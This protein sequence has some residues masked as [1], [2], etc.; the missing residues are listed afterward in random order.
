MQNTIEKEDWDIE[1]YPK[2]K[3]LDFNLKE[4]WR[5]RDLLTLFVRRDFVAVYK[6]TIFGPLWFFIQPILTTIMFM[7]VFGGIAKMS[8][9]G[10][11]QAVFY[12]SGIV[13][14]NYFAA[15]LSTTSNTFATNKG[16]FGKVYFPR[17]ISPVSV[18]ISKLLT[19]GVQFM[20]FI[21]VF[22]YFLIFTDAP[23][24]PN[25]LMLLTPLLI[26]MTA[27]IALGLGL[28]ITSLT[29]KYRD[30]TFLLGF[31]I[32]LGMYAT[33]VIYPASSIEGKMKLVIM[34]NPMSSIIETFRYAFLG[35]GNFSWI[36][37]AYSFIVMIIVLVL[38][39]ITFNKVEKSFMDTV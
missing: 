17:I 14:W 22:A 37:L 4:V 20:L 21:V 25:V 18:V 11:P 3:L 15:A 30:F 6:Q 1:I 16:V 33:P 32:Q 28:I 12:L 29:T 36:G 39:M 8:T 31:I 9:D 38:G 24:K 23:I 5:Y 26:I 19:F 2:S 27:G 13:L 7:V 10:M 34:A 35:V